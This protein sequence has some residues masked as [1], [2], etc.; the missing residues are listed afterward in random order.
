MNDKIKLFSD[1]ETLV[2]M[3]RS[4][5]DGQSLFIEEEEIVEKVTEYDQELA[6]IKRD[7]E[8]D[9]YDTSAEM[10]DR[11]IEIITKKL[12]Q[13]LK[14][15]IK[16]K[17]AVLEDLNEDE[18]DQN[19]RLTLL[20]ASKKSREDFIESMQ[21]RINN[22][23]DAA[24]I[25]RYNALINESTKD[26][27]KVKVELDELQNKYNTL[28][29]NITQSSEDLDLLEE[30][31]KEKQKVLAEAQANLENPNAYIDRNKLE[32]HKEKTSE[33]EGKKL[34]LVN[35]LE[36]IRKDPKYLEL[37]IKNILNDGK[38]PDQAIPYLKE[39]IEMAEAIPYMNMPV[40]NKLE[41]L[42]LK[43]TQE[44]D[45]FA[46]EID[47]KSYNVMETVS[48]EQ[49]RMEF[50]KARIAKW[51]KDLKELDKKVSA[52]DKDEQFGYRTI[53]DSLSALIEKIKSELE[54]YTKV[55]EEESDENLSARATF[56]SA[57]DEKREDLISAE[58]IAS[59]FREDEANDISE[60]SE[61]LKSKRIEI[62]QNIE[63]AN[64][65]IDDI[66]NRLITKKSGMID[67]SAQKKD[68]EHLKDLADNVMD[69]K[70]RRQFKETPAEI[71]EEIEK[72]IGVEFNNSSAPKVEEAPVET[73]I[74]EPVIAETGEEINVQPTTETVPEAPIETTPEI[75]PIEEPTEEESEIDLS[76]SVEPV[77]EAEQTVTEP[78][79]TE[80]KGIKVVDS[81]NITPDYFNNST[82]VA[83]P[84]ETTPVA[85]PAVEQP[86]ENQS[87]PVNPMTDFE[88][89]APIAEEVQ[90]EQPIELTSTPS[91]NE[92]E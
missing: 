84:E 54:E 39:L 36:E 51:N 20:R 87:E 8:E 24:V 69:I 76:A 2:N 70:H 77:T 16:E 44:R 43:A 21:N 47:Q 86:I 4:K 46:T 25:E 90:P 32:R 7:F 40:D 17:K 18:K 49:I 72:L 26:L 29:A 38:N 57:V 73:P 66:K 55:Y 85:E 65:E 50:L 6:E 60:A 30:K 82:A 58:Q 19:D 52:I 37:K 59:A 74:E 34:E 83:T 79:V 61:L 71:A 28:Q 27:D 63:E 9:S 80:P 33:I 78:E 41:E 53:D 1:I 11:N 67:I 13:S 56:K 92:E 64:K 75:T 10:A 62:E 42:L 23:T 31:L 12:I 3:C 88:P 91:T 89:I 68:K 15:D 14:I 45:S 35:R 5:S 48:P 81:M 22:S